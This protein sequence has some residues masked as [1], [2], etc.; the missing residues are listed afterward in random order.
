MAYS[1]RKHFFIFLVLFVI[2]CNVLPTKR[3]FL[4]AVFTKEN[5]R[6]RGHIF[7]SFV[8][9]SQIL[10]TQ[11]CLSRARC[12]STNFKA[13]LTHGQLQGLCEL[14]NEQ[15]LHLGREDKDLCY[16]QGWIY[17]RYPKDGK[18]RQVMICR[19]VHT[20]LLL[21]VFVCIKSRNGPNRAS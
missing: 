8:A 5:C 16:E 7:Q 15:P 12:Y 4:G 11:S 18:V 6:L 3:A 21:S 19:S 2:F 1:L 13:I 14:N 20:V 9:T 17:S 10:C